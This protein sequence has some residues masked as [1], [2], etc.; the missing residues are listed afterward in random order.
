LAV[1]FMIDFGR[2]RSDT[3]NRYFFRAFRALASPRQVESLSITWFLCG[4]F[5]VLWFPGKMV[6][7]ASILVL[8]VADPAA[9]VV[10]RVWGTHPLGKG[11]VEG[12]AAFFLAAVAVL[13]PFVGVPAAVVVAAIVSAAEALSARLDDNVVIPVVTAICLWTLTVLT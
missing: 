2:L 6:A 1:T 8:A 5:L 7:V 10:G 3:L 9:S 12:T 13:L 11:T 4:V